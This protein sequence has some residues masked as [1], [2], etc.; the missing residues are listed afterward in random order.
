MTNYVSPLL[1]AV[2]L[3]LGAPIA[4]RIAASNRPAA[5]VFVVGWVLADLVVSS[6]IRFAAEWERAVVFRLGKFLQ[7]KGPGLFLIV[8][9]V[10]GG[11]IPASRRFRLL[12]SR[13]SPRTTCRSV[14][15]QPCSSGSR[16]R[17]MRSSRCRTSGSPFCSTRERRCADVIGPMTLDQLVAER[18][19]IEAAIARH[20]ETDTRAWGLEVVG[21][22]M[23]DIDMPEEL[24]KMMSRQAS[25]ER[26]KRA[27]ITKAEGDKEAA[28]NLA[29]AARTMAESPGAMHLRTLQTIDGLGPSAS[30]TVVLTVP[31]EMMEILTGLKE[32]LRTRAS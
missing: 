12:G 15:M 13:S 3:V 7:T 31:V 26:E 30:N 32:M 16:T 21:I 10:S 6:A 25:A 17:R 22:R 1:F 9:L 27:N 29:V 14:S 24:K 28:V 2:L 23:E 18:E 20:V 4:A 5:L 19:Q 8:P 11:S